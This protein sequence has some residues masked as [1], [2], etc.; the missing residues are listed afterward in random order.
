[1]ATGRCRVLQVPIYMN[2][3]GAENFVARRLWEANVTLRGVCQVRHSCFRFDLKPFGCCRQHS[4]VTVVHTDTALCSSMCS[5]ICSHYARTCYYTCYISLRLTDSSPSPRAQ[6]APAMHWDCAQHEENS[7]KSHH[8]SRSLYEWTK[9]G[10]GM[11]FEAGA[12]VRRCK[13][14]KECYLADPSVVLAP[15]SGGVW[16]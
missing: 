9:I 11:T 7:N 1:M 12:R 14:M 6:F 3:L 2:M 4:Y 16:S 13:T 10:G 5:Q 15:C 8:P